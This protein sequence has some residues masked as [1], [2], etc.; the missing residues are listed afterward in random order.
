MLCE[1]PNG[2]M[3]RQDGT[4]YPIACRH[5]A[6]P[7]NRRLVILRHP[8]TDSSRNPVDEFG[9]GF[10]AERVDQ[11]MCLLNQGG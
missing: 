10:R 3:Q 1:F 5:P 11:Q 4:S 8:C 6:T 7:G 9:K 2:R